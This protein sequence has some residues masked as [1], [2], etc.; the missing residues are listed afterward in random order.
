M[1][2]ARI[3]AFLGVVLSAVAQ[4]QPVI[5][6][7]QVVVTR[8]MR[9]PQDTLI[10]PAF[11]GEIRVRTADSSVYV[12]VALAGKKWVRSSNQ[13]GGADGNNFPQGLN[14]NQSTDTL[15]LLLSGLPSLK[16]HI[17][18]PVYDGSETKVASG[19]GGVIITG[20]GTVP[21]PYTFSVPSY[22]GSETKL[23]AGQNIL[24]SGSGTI[25][26]PYLIAGAAIDST[27]W[28]TRARDKKGV[29]SLAALFKPSRVVS[30]DGSL[31]VNLISGAAD[32]FNVQSIDTISDIILTSSDGSVTIDGD[33][34]TIDLK[35][36]LS[37][38]GDN[39]GSQT[40]VTT[41]P[42]FGSGTI[43]SP[44]GVSLSVTSPSLYTVN[45]TITD[46]TRVATVKSLF[47]RDSVSTTNKVVI[48]PWE[49]SLFSSNLFG[50]VRVTESQTALKFN[51]SEIRMQ[52]T[53]MY[54]LPT[55]SLGIGYIDSVGSAH[56][57]RRVSYASRIPVTT[58]VQLTH[59]WYVDSMVA[60]KDGSETK[61]TQGAN[62]TITGAGTIASPYVINSTAAG[63]G[64]G[65]VS[66]VGLSMPSAFNVTG[67][68]ITSSGV[69]TV[70]AAG[71]V[72]QYI[73]GNGS[74]VTFP[75][76]PTYDGSETKLTQGAN[77]TITGAGTI[78]SPYVINS[79]AAGGGG[80]TVSSVG[81]S[82]PSGFSVSGS[83]IT[84]SGTLSVSTSL[85]GLLIGNGSGFSTA[86]VTSPLSYA[87]GTLS[88]SESSTGS[89]GW[90]S[91]S[92]FSAFN[93]KQS[94]LQWISQGVNQGSAGSIG[95]INFTGNVT[96]S[97][98]GSVLTVNVPAPTP[99]GNNY[100]S[101]VTI[102]DG[103]FSFQRLGLSS[104][105]RSISTDLVP[106]G[107][108][109]YFN[110]T[111]ARQA[112]SLTTT[113]SSGPASYS[114]ASG[115]F[116][117]P[118]YTLAGLGGVPL[119][120]V[121]TINGVAQDLSSNGSWSVGTVTSVAASAGTGISVSGSPIT[122]SGTL[123]ITNTAPDQVVTLAGTGGVT[124]SGTYPNFTV[125]GSGITGI[126]AQKSSISTAVNFNK[127]YVKSTGGTFEIADKVFKMGHQSQDDLRSVTLNAT[128][129]IEQ[130]SFTTGQWI[131]A[132]T[133]P[134]GYRPTGLVSFGLPFAV[135]TT[136]N[137]STTPIRGSD[138][139]T[140]IVGASGAVY[141]HGAAYIDPDTGN[142]FV[143][144]ES[145]IST[146]TLSGVAVLVLPFFVT[147][148]IN[149][150]T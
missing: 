137:P 32:T 143:R 142:L 59:R 36:S 37:S 127:A 123:T 16:T 110:N 95:S 78:A 24:I 98:A 131:L 132:A 119:G 129:Y 88:M 79:T 84:S 149:A 30:K 81:L 27:V 7:P 8:N 134:S 12:G 77:V 23:S 108:R 73:A 128:L 33:Q 44:L 141:G 1:R 5:Q 10:P 4:S 40:V 63:G 135:I 68:P 22:N 43:A 41:P 117:I 97:A 102:T 82:M 106:E 35:V 75:S 18:V 130:S 86:S 52:G 58:D 146:P 49:T 69:L 114:S 26:N 34:D 99:D 101:D 89:S 70:T 103:N 92:N 136:G 125:S 64:G 42:L 93:N 60:I 100:L 121:L 76:I 94:A 15:T 6:T 56:S 38:I 28:T 3:L 21:N 50:H 65:T 139:T 31:A 124:T 74:L 57:G 115:V 80:G 122:S 19:T 91:S 20:T 113:G 53:R 9:P 67:S 47:F 87:S 29:D 85:S 150:N 71:S 111:R 72:G 48:A 25:A 13:S 46:A 148:L 140:G 144:V 62:V 55:D 147:Y 133:I 14:Y 45:D 112:L 61:L 2:I 17:P 105:N 116:N 109:L 96:A 54:L 11:L 90:L 104:L 51:T 39:W 83:P 120:R 118:E 145:V 138:G 66:S 107:S 126:F